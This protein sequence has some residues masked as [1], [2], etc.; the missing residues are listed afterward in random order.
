MKKV[1]L[2]AAPHY[3][4]GPMPPFS[5]PPGI[6]AVGSYLEANGVPVELIDV[7]MDF[8]VAQTDSA[9]HVIYQRVASYLS[10][11]AD[12]IAWIGISQVAAS[13][14][15]VGGLL[16]GKELHSCLPDI[17]LVFG[18]YFI[19]AYYERVLREYPFISAVVRGD[20]ERAALAISHALDR[21]D[22]FPSDRI[23]NLAWMEDE[24]VHANPI[25]PV[26]LDTLP[27]VDFGL[28]RHFRRYPFL[29]IFTSRGC[30]FRC[31][32]CIEYD[33][34][35]FSMS[36]PEWVAE[37][38]DSID[39][40]AAEGVFFYDP[41]FG[42]NSSMVEAMCEVM[43]GRQLTYMMESR[44]DVLRPEHVPA[45]RD[46]GVQAIYLGTESASPATLLRMNKVRTLSDAEDYNRKAKDLLRVCFENDVT[47]ML[48]YML[49]FPGDTEADYK[50]SLTFAQEA[51]QLHNE[52]TA[53]TGIQTGWQSF[54]SLTRIEDGSALKDNIADYP[55]LT[56]EPTPLMGEDLV[57]SPSPGVD[58]ELAK[59]YQLQIFQSCCNTPI[60]GK[61]LRKH[62]WVPL[63]AYFEE[64]PEL[65]D[66]DGV[67]MVDDGMRHFRTG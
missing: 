29:N 48:S 24:T 63:P 54:A 66:E 5:P 50:A 52:I 39:P 61:R 31:N 8:G 4:T 51:T 67:A 62:L 12:D 22:S 11:Q 45:L 64:H 60:S 15:D 33:M 21:G 30:P 42:I 36:S 35:P 1:V 23:P 37:Q 55:G 20:G 28:L 13:K 57:A 32:Y 40:G 26:P 3:P 2:I 27:V 43:K 25:E 65:I 17:P 44:A 59:E 18:S 46:A 34:R 38:L 10:E 47:P 56:L 6:L 14:P 16:L 19:T 9:E 7:K 58:L 53:R 49:G 41:I